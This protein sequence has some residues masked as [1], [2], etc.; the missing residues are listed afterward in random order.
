MAEEQNDIKVEKRKKNK[1]KKKRT[2]MH[3]GTDTSLN[4]YIRTENP[5]R[6]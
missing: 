4:S 3:L 6:Q 1:I 5:L 2:K